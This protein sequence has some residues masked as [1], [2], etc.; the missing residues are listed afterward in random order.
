MKEKYIPA[1]VTVILLDREDMITTSG[2]I[3]NELPDNNL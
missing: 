3:K 1:E 2:G